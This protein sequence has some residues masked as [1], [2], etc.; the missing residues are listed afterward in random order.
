MLT[1]IDYGLGNLAS[2]ANMV[3]RVGG[4]SRLSSYPDDLLQASKLIL[5]GVGSFDHGMEQLHARGLIPA[6]KKAVQAGVPILGICL[7]MQLLGKG[8]EEGQKEGLGFIDATFKRFAFKEPT[9]KV[10]HVGWNHL[11]VVRE[12]P[13]LPMNETIRF[14]FTHSYHAMPTYERDVI[15]VTEYGYSFP[16]VYGKDNIWGVQFHPEKSHRFGMGLF[17][18]FLDYPC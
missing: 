1:I 11:K 7:G 15:A 10:P 3:H 5:P 4:K 8:S 12:N 13:L 17:K 18:K 6:I 14:Y 9:L 16:A 2:V